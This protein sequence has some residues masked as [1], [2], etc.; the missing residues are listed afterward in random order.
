MKKHL[1]HNIPDITITSNKKVIVIDVA[2]SIIIEN[3][4]KI[5]GNI[6]KYKDLIIKMDSLSKFYKTY[7]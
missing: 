3:W 6:T 1:E 7:P 4:G 5:L 2:M